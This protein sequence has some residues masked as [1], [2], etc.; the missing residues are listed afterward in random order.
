MKYRGS[1][2]ITGH[3]ELSFLQGFS[4]SY[5]TPHAFCS[6]Q[7]RGG[8]EVSVSVAFYMT[9]KL[10][11]QLKN[12]LLISPHAPPQEWQPCRCLPMLSRGMRS[13]LGS[14]AALKLRGVAIWDEES[15]VQATS[16]TKHESVLT[17]SDVTCICYI[18]CASCAKEERWTLRVPTKGHS[19]SNHLDPIIRIP[20]SSSSISPQSIWPRDNS[21]HGRP[22]FNTLTFRRQSDKLL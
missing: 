1:S 16:V 5:L 3:I 17:L 11:S 18:Q 10:G 6:T 22:H 14:D 19:T 7:E 21:P 9:V 8:R 20:Q 15:T 4:A 2:R 13:L 12:A